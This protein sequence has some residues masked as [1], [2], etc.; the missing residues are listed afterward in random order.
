MSKKLISIVIPVFNEEENIPLIYAGLLK[1]L[2]GLL[3]NYDYEI[4]FVDDGSQDN[5]AV[6]L[7]NF[8]N[9][10]SHVKFIQFSRNFGKELALSAGL[11]AAGGDAVIMI[12]ADLQHPVELVP[13]FMEKWQNGAE[14]VIGV[15]NRN[16]GGG[17]V[18]KIGS[19]LFYK[20]M[21]TIGDTKITPNATDYRLLDRKVVLAF[22]RFTEHGRMTRGLID[23]L[24]FKREYINFDS[25]GRKN[26]LACYDKMKL[27]KLALCTIVNHSLFP[28]KLAGYLGVAIIVLFGLAGFLLFVG[29]YIVHNSFAM[30]FS[31]PAQLAILLV[32][33]VGIILSCLGL[34][35]LYIANIQDEVLKRPTYVIRKSNFNQMI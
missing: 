12:D 20:I 23:W 8:A 24:G 2:N 29:R 19:L 34:V 14:V 32:F 27:V 9:Q 7:E 21:D 6:V 28:L 26:G 25:N 5:S 15:R 16:I 31:G 3:D 11:D 10:N 1:T 17:I 13:N 4:I 18:K 35:A 33:L 30:S 22:R